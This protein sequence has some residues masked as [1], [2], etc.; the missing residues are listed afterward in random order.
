MNSKTLTVAELIELLTQLPQA[1]EVIS[2]EGTGIQGA[3][4][5]P[6][7]EPYHPESGFV[8]LW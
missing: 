4:H 5:E 6:A 7:S 3:A 1:A 2:Y 8:E